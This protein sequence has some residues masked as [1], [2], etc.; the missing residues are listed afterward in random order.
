AVNA[1]FGYSVAGAGDLNG[2][3]ISDVAIG[4][5]YQPKFPG[6]NNGA[7]H[8]FRG[9]VGTGLNATAGSVLSGVGNANFGYCISSAGDMNGDGYADLLIGAPGTASGNGAAHLYLGTAAASMVPPT[10]S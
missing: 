1:Q 8:V 7:V 5:P 10:V 2:D 4:A 3:G 9:N 6:T